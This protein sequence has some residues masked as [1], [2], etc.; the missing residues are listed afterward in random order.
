MTGSYFPGC[1]AE[2]GAFLFSICQLTF[3]PPAATGGEGGAL[4]GVGELRSF[5]CVNKSEKIPKLK[6]KIL[7]YLYAASATS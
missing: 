6:D 4:A 7:S 3:G 5:I 1:G 2:V